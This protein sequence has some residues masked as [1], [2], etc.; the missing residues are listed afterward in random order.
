MGKDGIKVER[1]ILFLNLSDLLQ[2][3]KESNWVASNFLIMF[4]HTNVQLQMPWL[5]ERHEGICD[6]IKGSS[7]EF[8]AINIGPESL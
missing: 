2:L 7:V 1:E 8:M 4:I 5:T 6:W 3:L